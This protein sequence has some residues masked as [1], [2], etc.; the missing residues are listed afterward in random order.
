MPFP[1]EI[2]CA[3]CCHCGGSGACSRGLRRTA[4]CSPQPHRENSSMKQI[5]VLL[6]F[7]VPHLWEHT[8]QGTKKAD[9]CS[10]IEGDAP[11]SEG[12]D[13]EEEEWVEEL[14]DFLAD[15]ENPRQRRLLKVE[16]KQILEKSMD[17]CAI[18]NENKQGKPSQVVT[19]LG[20]FV[21]GAV[22]IGLALLKH[23]HCGGHEESGAHA[24]HGH[25]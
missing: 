5:E 24:G 17:T 12:V 23:E 7:Y 1:C 18:D 14:R 2:G 8:K 19:S 3:V 25:L 15:A 22:L 11:E 10:R 9:T 6:P 20:L 4:N 13:E 21:L 16:L